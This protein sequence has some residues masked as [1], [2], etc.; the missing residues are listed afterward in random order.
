M[1]K[2][3]ATKIM[4]GIVISA[5]LLGAGV[6]A[7]HTVVNEGYVIDSQGH[8][9]RSGFGGCVRT[10]YWTAAM[11]TV[12]CD[13]SLAKKPAPAP[14]VAAPPPPAPIVVTPPPVV[15][16]P[17]PTP[18]VVTPP[19]APEFKTEVILKPITIEGT[20][21]DSGSAQLKPAANE[22]LA[23]VVDFATENSDSNLV[24]TGFTDSQG[25]ESKNVALSAARAVAVKSYLVKQ[26]IAADR[27]STNGMG[28]VNPVGD[29]KTSAG[30]AANRRVEI[31]STVRE[32]KKVRVK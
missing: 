16:V 31:T 15:E 3:S 23:E 14:V 1:K 26:G 19:P 5:A 28:S 10:G 22:K 9:V 13:S 20:G 25:S 30:R 21:F 27:I 24:V 18:V 4:I 11:A 17:V 32:E 12:E 7:A 6:A 2:M 29:N 8:P